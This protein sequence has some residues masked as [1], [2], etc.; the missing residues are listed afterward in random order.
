MSTFTHAGL[1]VSLEQDLDA[2]SPAEYGDDQVFIVT[3]RNREFQVIPDGY[4]CA[5]I[6]EET[7]DGEYGDFHVYPLR[8]YVH[9]GVSLSLGNS[10]PFD[11][12]WDSGQIGFVLVH[13]DCNPGHEDDTAQSKVDEWNQYLSGD[14]WFYSVQKDGVYLDSCGGCYGY[15]YAESE[16]KSAAEYQAGTL[17]VSDKIRFRVSQVLA[18]AAAGVKNSIST[19]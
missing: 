10:Y 13:K 1:E 12:P 14:V 15:E 16:A 3:T 4:D 11:C 9:S 8:A 17:S 19:V 5:T 2:E 7:A 18:T 6:G